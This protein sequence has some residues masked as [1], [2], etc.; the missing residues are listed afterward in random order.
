[1][2]KNEKESNNFRT[3]DGGSEKDVYRKQK[4]IPDTYAE[5]LSGRNGHP[6]R[7]ESSYDDTFR[8]ISK[9]GAGAAN[10]T[11]SEKAPRLS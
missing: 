10:A 7:S 1:M 2:E 8:V 6:L 3:L 5:I 9:E 4:Q 11:G